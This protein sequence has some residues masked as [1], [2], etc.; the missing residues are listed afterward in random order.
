MSSTGVS[1]ISIGQ[2]NGNTF[3]LNNLNSGYNSAI[4]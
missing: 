1:E 3:T 4:R 2:F